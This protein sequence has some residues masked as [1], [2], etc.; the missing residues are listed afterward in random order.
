M[1]TVYRLESG[2]YGKPRIFEPPESISPLSL[3]DLRIDLAWLFR[4]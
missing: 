2:T 3:P 1:V 4:R